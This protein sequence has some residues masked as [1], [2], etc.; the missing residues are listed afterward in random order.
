LTTAPPS[1]LLL[2]LL[3]GTYMLYI[4][5]RLHFFERLDTARDGFGTAPQILRDVRW[6]WVIGTL[7]Y[8]GAGH[9][10]WQWPRCSRWYP[11]KLLSQDNGKRIYLCETWRLFRVLQTAGIDG[12]L[13]E[14]LW[15]R[16]VFVYAKDHTVQSTWRRPIHCRSHWSHFLT[17]R[18]A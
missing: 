5:C 16:A 10:Q 8:D 2:L 4:L 17:R 11:N 9:F 13:D 18:D 15:W 7:D 12:V 14:V 6:H 3:W 1:L